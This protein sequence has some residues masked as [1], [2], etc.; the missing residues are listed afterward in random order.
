MAYPSVPWKLKI[1]LRRTGRMKRCSSWIPEMLHPFEEKTEYSPPL[2]TIVPTHFFFWS[3]VHIQPLKPERWP[4]NSSLIFI[5]DFFFIF[6]F[7]Y[8]FR[9]SLF[10][11]QLL[12]L[13]PRLL[14]LLD[15]STIHEGTFSQFGGKY[16]TKSKQNKQLITSKQV[17]LVERK[18]C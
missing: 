3:S 10:T 2:R 4:E 6:F 9:Y 5:A 12:T 7:N 8:L 15:C 18:I 1:V 16:Q 11:F 14:A 17:D 13:I